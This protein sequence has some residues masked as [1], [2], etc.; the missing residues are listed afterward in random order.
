MRINE[1]KK[2]A[3][4]NGYVLTRP[5][6]NYKLER[7]NREN[8]ITISGDCENKIWISNIRCCDDKDFKMIKAAVKFAETP[9]EDREEEKKFYL[10]HRYF[11]YPDGSSKYFTYNRFSDTPSLGCIYFEDIDNAKFTLKEIEEIKEK[12]DTDLKDF[13]L[14]E[15]KDEW[16]R[17]EATN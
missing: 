6:D 17:K 7:N 16:F 10:E 14:V 5:F 9:I 2:I 4:E 12:F 8:Y 3:E 13:E 1:L 15:V 11:K